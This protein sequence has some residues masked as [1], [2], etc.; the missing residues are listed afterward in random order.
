MT[1]LETS[2]VGGNTTEAVLSICLFV[3]FVCGHCRC[4]NITTVQDVLQKLS[5]RVVEIK[6]KLQDGC[7][8]PYLYL[9]STC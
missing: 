3:L 7:G 5:R 4:D 2:V 9:T 1:S 6:V 8:P